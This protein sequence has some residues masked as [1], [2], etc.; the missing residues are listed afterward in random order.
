MTVDA[1]HSPLPAIP[2]DPRPGEY[3]RLAREIGALED[4]GLQPFGVAI[5]SSS[6][7]DFFRPVLVVEG[8]RAGFAVDLFLGD[9]GQLEQPILDDAS[10]LHAAARDVLLLA[11]Q[12]TDLSPDAFARYYAS[13]GEELDAVCVGLTDRLLAAARAFRERTGRPVLVANYAIP[14][15]L[16]LGPFDAGDP[17][18]LTHRLAAHNAR[19]AEA[20]HAEPDVYV[21]D[22]AGLVRQ[23]GTATWSDPRLELLARTTVASDNQPAMARHLLRALTALRRR[24]AKCLVLDLDNTLWGGVVGD[25]GM[26]GLQLGDDWPGSPF[27]AFQRTVLGLRDRGIL[28]ALASKND[29][30]VAEEV[31]RRHPEM[32]IGWD[33]LAAVRVNWEPKSLNM[34]AIAEEL[35]IGTDALVLFDDNP[36]ERAEVRA[37]LP[38]AGV[39]EVPTDPVRYRDALLS[40]GFFDQIGLSAED[41]ERADMYRV[42]RQR[43]TLQ[44]QSGTVE[45]F[46]ESLE[47]E[48]EVASAG[49]ETLGRIAQLIAKTNQFNLTTRR[50]PPAEVA[51]LSEADDAVVASLRLRDR[52]GDQGLIA[53][54]IL[55]RRGDAGWLDTFL[56][57]CRVMNRR[58]EHAM[59]AYLIEHARALGCT[60]LIGEY[61]PTPKNHMVSGLLSD[62][63]FAPHGES[64]DGTL[65]ALELDDEPVP[66]PG[67]IK[68][69]DAAPGEARAQEALT[70]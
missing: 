25:D 61:R 37:G 29:E 55:Q 12:P 53:V 45:D 62:L 56:M 34:R 5:L 40:S 6:T 26:E 46:L 39:V 17:K 3:Q 23:T 20:A 52:F 18:G 59:M 2:A 50:H 41:R 58:V 69:V 36:V 54:G 31:F 32:L 63:G 8:A 7:L 10:A 35:N 13:G 24:P 43:V 33:D 70:S 15:A 28:L 51:R 68:R 38:E 11:F 66:W 48:A 47:M 14:A 49:P 16:P 19:L 67:H 27:K 4:A 22:Y 42:E 44:R 9:F 60:R 21:W 57:S 65:W 30:A 1:R 64:A